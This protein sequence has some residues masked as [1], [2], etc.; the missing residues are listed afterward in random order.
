MTSMWR[1]SS[2]WDLELREDVNLRI[3]LGRKGFFFPIHDEEIDIQTGKRN[4][5]RSH[6][7]S[8]LNFRFQ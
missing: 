6:F 5:G 4:K 3:S 8:S 1:L 2:Q 7:D